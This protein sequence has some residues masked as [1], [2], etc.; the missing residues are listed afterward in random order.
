MYNQ[1]LNEAK[2]TIT[3]SNGQRINPL[4]KEEIILNL[5]IIN[6]KI[7]SAEYE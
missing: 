1:M 6:G 7:V 3:N 5:G 4:T 2:F